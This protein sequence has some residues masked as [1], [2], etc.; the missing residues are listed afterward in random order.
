MLKEGKPNKFEKLDK[1]V[2][3]LKNRVLGAISQHKPNAS[4]STKPTK[5]NKSSRQLSTTTVKKCRNSFSRPVIASTVSNKSM[6]DSISV[7][8]IFFPDC[9]WCLPNTRP[10][11][12]LQQTFQWSGCVASHYPNKCLFFPCL[13]LPLA[14]HYLLV[15][16]FQDYLSLWCLRHPVLSDWCAL[17]LAVCHEG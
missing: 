10:K 5:P 3:Y 12:A 8:I 7:L 6:H 11:S 2:N 1:Y 17:D 4:S 13:F 9:A 14:V 15:Q 16:L